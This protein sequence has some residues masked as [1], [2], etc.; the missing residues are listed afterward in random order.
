ML[1]FGTGHTVRDRFRASE[2]PSLDRILAEHPPRMGRLGYGGRGRRTRLVCGGFGLSDALPA[3]LLAVL[4]TTL[5]LDAASVGASGVAG[6]LD[7]I[8]READDAQP[9]ATAVF[10]KVADV[11]L[12]QAL[13]TYFL[14][15]ERAGTVQVGPLQHPA[16][17]HAIELMRNHLD[18]PWTVARLA[19]EVGMSRT[20][21]VARFRAL[22]GQ[23][24]MRF[25]TRLRLSQAAGHLTTSDQTVYAI[26]RRA[27]YESEASFSKA[28][29]REF[30]VAPGSYRRRSVES[31]VVVEREL[32]ME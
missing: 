28:F 5:R 21:F 2:E 8:T 4:P 24:P 15:A 18:Q 19:R 32:V 11:F 14:N 17:G 7:V 20:L 30:G 1:P 3:R 12:T 31:P 13:R 25:L 27:G 9:G 26:A 29:K 22:V 23:A 6:L 16:I 10:A